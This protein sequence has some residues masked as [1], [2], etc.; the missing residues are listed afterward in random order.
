MP[1]DIDDTV[2]FAGT[3]DITAD[4]I[5]P[6]GQKASFTPTKTENAIELLEQ[7]LCEG[8]MPVTEMQEYFDDLHISDKTVQNAKKELL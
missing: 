1:F 8:A 4:E 3:S 7:L 5:L 6:G 2:R